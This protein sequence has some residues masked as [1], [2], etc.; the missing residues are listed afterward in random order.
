MARAIGSTLSAAIATAFLA[1]TYLHERQLAQAGAVLDAAPATARP[2]GG[3][4]NAMPC[5]PA[6]PDPPARR[7]VGSTLFIR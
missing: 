7:E 2:V 6:G 4:T 5:L 3:T 1:A